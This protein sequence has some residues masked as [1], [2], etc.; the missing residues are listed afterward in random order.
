MAETAMLGSGDRRTLSAYRSRCRGSSSRAGLCRWAYGEAG[1]APQEWDGSRHPVRGPPLNQHLNAGVERSGAP[2]VDTPCRSAR[3][4]G[5]QQKEADMTMP[6]NHNET[7]LLGGARHHIVGNHN[8]TLLAAERGK[9]TANHSESLLA[10]E[11]GYLSANH[12]ETLL[13][14]EWGVSSRATT[15]RRCSP[16]SE[17]SSRPITTS[18]CSPPSDASSRGTTT[19]RCSPPWEASSGP[20]TT[21]RS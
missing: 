12:N 21:R 17:A 18:R 19:R 14:A 5:P 9:L 7:L 20:I 16:L 13:A 1:L 15:T 3:L 4:R 11:R 2:L 8:E 6:H 10:A